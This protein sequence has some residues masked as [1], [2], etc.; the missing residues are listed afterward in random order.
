M[1]GRQG[2]GLPAPEPCHLYP[3]HFRSLAGGLRPQMVEMHHRVA[4]CPR[5]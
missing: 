5:I 2:R 4:H 3:Q 1:S